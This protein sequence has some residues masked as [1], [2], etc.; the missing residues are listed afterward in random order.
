M[1]FLMPREEKFFDMFDEFSAILTRAAGKFLE[2]VE[3]FDRLR[4]R[5]ED[6]RKEEHDAQRLDALMHELGR[7]PRLRR[8]AER[9][10]THP[11]AFALN[12]SN[13]VGPRRPCSVVGAR[14]QEL[15]SLAEIRERHALRISVISL[16]DSL[17]SC[18]YRRQSQAPPVSS[19][20]SRRKL[21]RSTSAGKQ[22]NFESPSVE[23]LLAQL[24]RTLAGTSTTR[25]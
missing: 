17:N 23:A 13:V 16:C 19:T 25:S 18:R 7:V 11:R 10:L 4:E 3:Q 9:A 2:M 24:Q 21:L 12:V 22:R 1:V 8:F 15:Y 6:L 20:R 5:G 14:V